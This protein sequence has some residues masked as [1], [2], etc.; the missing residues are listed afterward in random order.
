M[1]G[2]AVISMILFIGLCASALASDSL[3]IP[4][5]SL[6]NQ[7]GQPVNV[8]TELTG[9]GV[10]IVNFIFTSC[11][12][13]CTPM[14][15]NFGRLQKML[16]DR[17]DKRIRLVS[18]TVDSQTDT[19][20][21]LDRWASQFHANSRWTLLTGSTAD[22][23]KVLKAFGVYT[24]DKLTHSSVV[25]MLNAAG[26]S[27]RSD[28]LRPPDEL[29]KLALG[30]VPASQA[31]PT[32]AQTNQSPAQRYFTDTLLVDQN[33]VE[34]RFYTDLIKGKV[35]IIN[36]IFTSCKNTCPMMTATFA[37]L[38]DWLG[39][40][41]NTDV[42]MISISVDPETDTPQRLKVYA[43]SFKARPGWFFLTGNKENVATV[44]RKLGQYVELKE[45]HA[46]IFL[47][48]NDRTG[49]WKKAFGM[50]ATEKVIETLDSVLRDG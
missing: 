6:I 43:D 24:P 42:N 40:R 35:V 7:H 8:S 4:A 33:G 39:A 41:L 49:L 34:H 45:D 37:R 50:A 38:Q 1:P 46:N 5:V 30:L 18:I 48:G 21:R 11:Q 31:R 26:E 13:I 19:P 32:Q 28:G 44:L 12:T 27:T 15:A 20:A 2:K 36:V 14:G 23:N 47:I 3:S 10:A 17:G 9:E 22:V 29:A 16:D 25:V